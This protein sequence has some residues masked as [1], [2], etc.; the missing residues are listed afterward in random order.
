MKIRLPHLHA[1]WPFALA[2]FTLFTIIAGIWACSNT[3]GD[4]LT[5]KSRSFTDEVSQRENLTFTFDRDVVTDSMLN[6]WDSTAYIHFDPPIKGQFQWKA[7]NELVFSPLAA[8]PPGT[9][10][11]ATP[12]K[13][14]GELKPDKKVKVKTE[15]ISF[16]TPYLALES[17]QMYWKRPAAGENKGVLGAVLGFNYEVDPKSLAQNLTIEIDNNTYHPKLITNNASTQIEL[18]VE[19]V[20][21]NENTQAIFTVNKAVTLPGGLSAT[22]SDVT[23]KAQSYAPGSMTVTDVSASHDGAEGSVYVALNQQITENTALEKLISFKQTVNFEVDM[24]TNGF[25]LRSADFD[26]TKVYEVTIDGKI[27][28]VFGGEMGNDVT[29]QIAFGTIEPTIR[30]A[31][32]NAVY[33]SNRGAKNMAIQIINVPK[34][35]VSISKIFENNLYA[36][37][38]TGQEYGWYDEYHED[39]DYYNYFD[40]AYYNIDNYGSPVYTAEIATNKLQ[41]VGNANMRLLNIDFADKLPQFDGIYVVKIEDTEHKYV[42]SSKIFAFSDL[43]IIAKHEKNRLHVFVN[44]IR[45]A[46]PIKGAQVNFISKSNQRIFTATTNDQGVA[47]F[48][49]MASRTPGFTVGMLTVDYQDDYNFL[50]FDKTNVDLTRFEIGGKMPNEA[51]YEAFIYGGRDIYRPGETINLNTIVRDLAWNTPVNIPVK[52]KVLLPNGREYKTIRK[53]LNDQGGAE[54]AVE[55]PANMVTG[56]YNVEVY[57]ANDLLLATKSISVEEF[58][59]DRIKLEVNASA[60]EFMP[61]E[62][63]ILE[64]TATNFFGPPASNRNYEV[65]MILERMPMFRDKFPDYNFSVSSNQ[66]LESVV[67]EGKTDENGRISEAFALKE[68]YEN[69]GILEGKFYVTVFDENGRPVR[70]LAPFKAITQSVFFGINTQNSYVNTRKPFNIPLIALDK[71]GSDANAKANLKIIRYE[72]RTAIQRAENGTLSYDSQ[73]EEIVELNKVVNITGK[74]NYEFIPRV[75]GDYE[76]R[77]SPQNAPEAYVA[78]SFYA[79]GWGDTQTTSFEVNRDGAIDISFDKKQYN[80]GEK[81]KVL[82][83]TPFEG[84]MLVTLERDKIIKHMYVETDKKS[85]EL[86]FDITADLTPNIF[87]SATLIRPLR[88]MNVPL[89]VA[90]GYNVVKVNN[91]STEIP[92]NITAAKAS[93]SDTKQHIKVKTKPGSEVTLAVVDE[94]ILQLKNFKTPDVHGYFYQQ[95]ALEVKSYDLYPFLFPEIQG[96]SLL[97]G[98]DGGFNLGKRL[99]PFSN[100]R[101]KLVSFWSGQKKADANGVVEYDID[102]PHFSGDLR[103]MAVAYNKN[104][105][106]SAEHNMIVADPIV[107]STGLPRFLSPGD[108]TLMPVTLANTT[109]KNAEA[110]LRVEAEGPVTVVGNGKTNLMLNANSEGKAEFKVVANNSV[111]VAKVRVIAEAMGEKFKEEIELPIR[112]AAT[113]QKQFTSGVIAG[114]NTQKITLPHNF[115]PESIDGSLVIS[116]SP[117]TE[118]GDDL[119]YLI[120]YPHGCL[121]QTISKAFPQIYAQDLIKNLRPKNV[122][123]SDLANENNP[124]YN[125]QTAIRKVESMQLPN[126][127]ISYWPGAQDENWWATVFAGHFLTEAKAAGFE[128]NPTVQEKLVGYLKQKLSKKTTFTYYYWST[129]NTRK[130]DTKANREAI[131]SLYVLALMNKADMPTMN[132]YK[133]N[134]KLLTPDSKYL[135]AAAFNLAGDREKAKAVMPET[136]P[137]E[138]SDREDFESFASPLRDKAIALCTMAQTDP[139]HPQIG[140]LS[141][142]LITDYKKAQYKNTQERVFTIL[143][144]GKIARLANNSNATATVTVNGKNVG[145]T[146]DSP[147]KLSYNTLQTNTVS[148]EV[149]GTGNMYYFYGLEGLS[150]DGTYKE[151]DQNLMVRKTFL[152]RTGKPILGR[153][154]NQNDLFVV[155]LTLQTKGVEQIENIVLTDILPGGFE[156]EN[157]RIS[158]L[159]DMEFTQDGAL[160]THKDIR[161]DRINLYVNAERKAQDYFYLVRAVSPGTYRMGPVSADAMYNNEYYSAHGGGTITIN[162]AM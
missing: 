14:L 38:R 75:S 28:G 31:E 25:A 82:F 42:Q 140:V 121:E 146:S 149:S 100:K 113:L 90:H 70:R 56:T 147:L 74:Q 69:L 111:G 102:I 11:K 151:T 93:R 39:G 77:I 88:D 36:F 160:P 81:A 50:M 104:A 87:V 135:L 91:P 76:I 103:V 15:A 37:F 7:T 27:S 26:I 18:E 143:A 61:G 157:S 64:G 32:A 105:F 118:F 23:I 86:S 137:N 96:G 33:L 80:V 159:P 98:G 145:S 148:I 99:N 141:K 30:F 46:T 78:Q 72:W 132:Y 139:N 58:M 6:Q 73:R 109:D 115:I 150:K 130:S 155:K 55:I 152:D 89:T 66:Y 12:T 106:G 85:R 2:F 21:L 47:I 124:N 92:V 84:K 20:P 158:D 107:V 142:Q 129:G 54:I 94:G 57:T 122:L 133:A 9:D 120:G 134:T 22:K 110:Q 4:A 43:G 97:T 40:Y 10:F 112:P 136:Y 16:H 41:S 65:E 49:D 153:T 79:Y 60:K 138:K 123:T 35:K 161:D 156:I 119:Q 162:K 34:V 45:D 3:L 67:N 63:M 127:G 95:R 154:F 53:T 48:D 117:L 71:D 128:T 1:F 144:F 68:T 24:L 29:Q 125:V 13:L 19:G 116:R 101:I 44:S 62:I 131:Y 126:G 17:T 52:F 59:P 51:Q 114:G 5:V 83:K 108:T 8:L